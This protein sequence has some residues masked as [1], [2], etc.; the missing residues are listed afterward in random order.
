MKV[1]DRELKE[2]DLMAAFEKMFDDQEARNPSE[3]EI[4]PESPVS[5]DPARVDI[6]YKTGVPTR[7]TRSWS[8]PEA[9]EWQERHAQ[10]VSDLEKGGL[11]AMIG[12]RGTGKTRHAAEAIRDIAP[13]KSHYITAMGIFL[14]IR[15]SYDSRSKETEQDVVKELSKCRLLV[16][17]EIQERGNTEWEDRLLT[18]IIDQRYSNMRPTILIANLTKKELAASLGPSIVSRLNETGSVIELTGPSHRTKKG[19]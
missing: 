7:Y 2:G 19:Y 1:N 12:G 3:P 10:I 8:Q 11:V 16:I 4:E 14:R 13:N 9:S 6:N 18:H 17:D 15:S 5:D